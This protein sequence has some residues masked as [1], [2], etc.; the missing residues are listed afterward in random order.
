MNYR[1]NNPFNFI[2]LLPSQEILSII[3]FRFLDDIEKIKENTIITTTT[4]KPS[5]IIP[6][7]DNDSSSY[8]SSNTRNNDGNIF[9][10]SSNI[11]NKLKEKLYKFKCN[12]NNNNNGDNNTNDTNNKN[13]NNNNNTTNINNNDIDNNNNNN[14][15]FDYFN[16]N[17][18]K[19]YKSTNIVNEKINKYI[20][21]ELIK[22]K[23]LINIDNSIDKIITKTTPISL[24]ISNNNLNLS[25]SSLPQKELK[26][27]NGKNKIIN[28][29]SIKYVF[30][31]DKIMNKLRKAVYSR[32]GL[33]EYQK[34][35]LEVFISSNLKNIFK[36]DYDIHETRIKKKY[37]NKKSQ[38]F[39]IVFCPRQFGKSFST[40]WF[41]SCAMLIL[42]NV[43][44]VV[45]SKN[46]EQAK[47][48]LDYV[49]G[50]FEI[51][52]KWGFKNYRVSTNNVKVFVVELLD[53]NGNVVSKNTLR[54]V[55]SSLDG[56]RGISANIIIVDEA[57]SVSDLYILT[58]LFPLLLIEGTSCIFITTIKNSENLMTRI[59]DI[60]ENTSSSFDNV[61]NNSI[62]NN[63]ND[64]IN[65]G[66]SG[67]NS[68]FR[69]VKYYT[70]C[71]SCRDKGLAA[72]CKH[73][74]FDKANWINSAVSD[75]IKKL[76]KKLGCEDL[77]KQELVGVHK[78]MSKQ[79][80][81]QPHIDTLFS[82]KCC[83]TF[84]TYPFLDI[85]KNPID[86]IFSFIDPTGGGGSDIGIVTGIARYGLF[87]IIGMESISAKIDVQRLNVDGAIKKVVGH[88][89]KI[90]EH[91]IYNKADILIWI[92]RNNLWQTS[93]IK[94]AIKMSNKL[95]EH[96]YFPN[97]LGNNV[98]FSSLSFT[99]KQ[100]K[101]Y[102]SKHDITNGLPSLMPSFRYVDSET[103]EDLGPITTELAKHDMHRKFQEYIAFT[104]IRIMKPLIVTIHPLKQEG[105]DD[106]DDIVG[107]NM[108]AWEYILRMFKKQCESFKLIFKKAKDFTFGKNKIG[109][110]G[111][112][113]TD[114]KDDLIIAAQAL[115]L[116]TEIFMI[117]SFK[118]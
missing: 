40:S 42:I 8:F 67:D 55:S 1:N 49:K 76:F 93:E 85:D 25:S 17:N 87:I 13:S 30:K 86:V 41:V 47:N 92:E 82:E 53:K 48:F 52:K 44:I 4:E 90:R 15:N 56:S 115:V 111:K 110:S 20:S 2:D 71:E 109:Y 60:H 70:A 33:Q 94:K 57:S 79:A 98:S 51:L 38:P 117:N 9:S 118:H 22:Y 72:S 62:F 116:W 68:H 35:F 34:N 89:I 77:M 14:N 113:A 65:D 104:K 3:H 54:C 36:E 73:N 31:K 64:D 69:V 101:S 107:L 83:C 24:E 105:A 99:S 58:V 97:V 26:N 59:A 75:T 78:N 100:N 6:I 81:F 21:K 91:N 11:N 114:G 112:G 45:V 7:L 61:N 74:S 96:V 50:G 108:E 88:Y 103:Q 37:G 16:N 106:A 43:K 18:N 23:K 80:F 84:N 12:I 29:G 32:E 39:S 66:L 5:E 95:R 102:K 63:N 19:R 10:L 28:M 27:N 46:L